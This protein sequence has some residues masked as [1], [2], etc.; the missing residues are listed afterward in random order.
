[1]RHEKELASRAA[2]VVVVLLLA[3]CADAPLYQ[4][5]V[6]EVAPA[7]REARLFQPARSVPVVPDAWWRLFNDPA[8]C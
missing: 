2:T 5:P 8:R 4:R 6:T 7:F 3:A 1:M